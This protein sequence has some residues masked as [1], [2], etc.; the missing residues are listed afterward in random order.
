VVAAALLWAPAQAG[1]YIYWG[2]DSPS[3]IARAELS[4]T[5]ANSSF[6]AAST[7]AGV[8]V[9]SQHV[10]WVN[11]TTNSIGRANLDGT[12][13][14]Q[15]FLQFTAGI[16]LGGV[17]VDATHIY[18]TE[19]NGG[20]AAAGDIGRANLN[21]SS[22]ST[23]FVSGLNNPAGVAVTS[24]HIY[25]S[26][27]AAG[28]GSIGGATLNGNSPP[29]GITNSFVPTG[30]VAVSGPLGLAVDGTSVY[31]ANFNGGSIGSAALNGASPAKPVQG[32]NSP[33]AVAV[34]AAHIYWTSTADNAIGRSNLDGS[35]AVPHFI[36]GAGNPEGIAVDGLIT[37][38]STTIALSPSAP[39][40]NNGW[41]T[42]SVGVDAIGNPGGLPVSQTRCEADPAA[43][44]ATFADLPPN[45]C[46]QVSSD[47]LH[48]A[49][50]A[51]SDTQNQTSPVVSASFKLDSTPP[52]LK[53]GAPPSLIAGGPR[54][55]VQASVTD[56]ESGAA[57]STVSASVGTSLPGSKTVT[58]TGS[59]IAGNRATVKCHYTVKANPLKPEPKLTARFS[60]AGGATVVK[61]MLL[62][63]VP[64]GAKVTVR[65]S[66]KGCPFHSLKPVL[67]KGKHAV[68]DLASLFGGHK[69]AAGA[70]VSVIVT[71]AHKNGREFVFTVRGGGKPP[72]QKLSQTA[73]GLDP[74]ARQHLVRGRV[75]DRVRVRDQVVAE[76]P[77]AVGIPLRLVLPTPRLARLG[78]EEVG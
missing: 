78:R 62:S 4:G 36:T 55:T 44:P 45:A 76:H 8:A 33:A 56:H 41:Y 9:D 60:S 24:T 14:D 17:A 59:D 73:A 51:S 11:T 58:L 47:G 7:P 32:L 64:H 12:N 6:E 65:C 57:A 67:K 10:Y 28:A 19:A 29:T 13:A 54:G 72:K 71:Q 37:P 50:A 61:A 23:S 15:T 5:G 2:N 39:N 53:C 34:D 30:S 46:G 26:N 3:G 18:W 16:G 48:T 20:G 21:G 1:A 68:T 77:L 35:S 40:G 22:Q 38:P 75:D 70:K 31:W 63:R 66:G 25:W 42:Q 69:L 74:L 27:F 52:T 49:F 43:A